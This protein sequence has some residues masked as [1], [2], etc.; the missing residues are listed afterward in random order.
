MLSYSHAFMRSCSRAL[1]PSCPL[2]IAPPSSG[3]GK[4]QVARCYV[5]IWLLVSSSLTLSPAL[6]S[7]QAKAYAPSVIRFP[8][9][10][11][12]VSSIAHF[13]GDVSRAGPN[14]RKQGVSW[15]EDV[16]KSSRRAPKTLPSTPQRGPKSCQRGSKRTPKALQE[17]QKRSHSIIIS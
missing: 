9:L 10:L 7:S 1:Q 4:N 6:S 11:V 16:S 14:S 5:V 13:R 2:A 15:A 17:H 12:Q 8:F 3:I